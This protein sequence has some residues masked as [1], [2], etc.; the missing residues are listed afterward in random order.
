VVRDELIEIR[1]AYG[2]AR[3]TEIN[4]DHLNRTTRI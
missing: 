3:R 4:R 2:D 1:E